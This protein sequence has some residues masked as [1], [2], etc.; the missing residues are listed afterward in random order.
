M[1]TEE[2]VRRNTRPA[3]TARRTQGASASSAA[4]ATITSPA[5]TPVSTIKTAQDSK[6]VSETKLQVLTS[7]DYN[8]SKYFDLYRRLKSYVENG[9]VAASAYDCYLLKKDHLK[10]LEYEGVLGKNEKGKDAVLKDI[11]IPLADKEE[12]ISEDDYFAMKSDASKVPD[13][14]VP[15]RYLKGNWTVQL[16]PESVE[17]LI[18]YNE[19]DKTLAVSDDLKGLIAGALFEQCV[20]MEGRLS[21]N[22]TT[23]KGD[24]M[25]DNCNFNIHT[26][27]IELTN[28]NRIVGGKFNCARVTKDPTEFINGSSL[29]YYYPVDKDGN[30]LIDPETQNRVEACLDIRNYG[31]ITDV[32]KH[33]EMRDG[34]AFDARTGEID[35][36]Y[37]GMSHSEI[38]QAKLK[39]DKRNLYDELN[40][41]GFITVDNVVLYRDGE[42][43]RQRSVPEVVAYYKNLAQKIIEKN[44]DILKFENP[45]EV[46]M[47]IYTPNSKQG[48][49]YYM[50]DDQLQSY[51]EGNCIAARLYIPE[52]FTQSEEA[53]QEACTYTITGVDNKKYTK[54]IPKAA[55]FE[56]NPKYSAFPKATENPYSAKCEARRDDLGKAEKIKGNMQMQ[57]ER[58]LSAFGDALNPK[59]K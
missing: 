18:R 55:L 5:S 1:P 27:A 6:G 43:V 51:M 46:A 47:L 20:V 49:F 34:T 15:C 36:Q 8:F 24:E 10:D 28:A 21:Y 50:T 35:P 33:F 31:S 25:R 54:R 13:G 23:G 48:L 58:R 39:A 57:R 4:A 30:Y 41:R 56:F 53:A 42:V 17:K 44:P 9:Y 29:T 12:Q 2:K 37:D 7:K 11:N 52:K 3:G 32:R 22:S 59:M 40:A 26:D 45:D 16:Y 38:L 19:Q 14:Y